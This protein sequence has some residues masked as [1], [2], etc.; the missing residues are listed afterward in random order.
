MAYDAADTPVAEPV[1]NWVTDWDWLDDQWGE[2][3]IEI[4]NGVREQ[5]P[6][7]STERYGRSFMPVTMEA[8]KTIAQDTE[9]FSSWRVGIS[10]PGT[11][12][13]PAPPITSDPPD[14]L[15]H[16]KVLLPSFS[17]KNIA[18]LEDEL[19]R[20]ARELIASLSELDAVDAADVYTQKI[21]VRGICALT[22]AP[23]SDADLYLDWI[24]RNFQIAPKRPEERIKINE[25]MSA[26]LDAL[27]S[28]RL[29]N[30]RDDMLTMIANAEID[31]EEIPWDLKTGYV[32]LLIIAGIDTTWSALGSGLWHFAQHP[33]EVAQL[34]DS[35]NDSLLWQTASEEVLRYYAPVSMARQVVKDVEVTG[36]PMRAGEQT[37]INFPAA[38]H[39]PEAFE[40]PEEF[41]IDRLRNRHVAFGMGIHRCVGSNLARLELLVGL[42]EWI[43]AFPNYSLD[44]AKKTLWAN[45]QVRGPRNIP[46]LLHR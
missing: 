17:P 31:G 37:L 20:Y 16:R 11:P 40:N 18:G 14:H 3:A 15:G 2:N 1:A 22:G 23:E 30:P 29:E 5:C 27:L 38:N 45:G 33:E 10:M 24:Y 28:D 25:E 41:Q 6:V 8:A 35:P 9:H 21:P 46:V 12:G 13:F 34:V 26:H 39:D 32:S 7:A 4:F 44:P 43:K 19:R 36:C 42:Q